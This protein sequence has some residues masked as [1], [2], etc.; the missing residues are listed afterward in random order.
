MSSLV[1]GYGSIGS[2]HAAILRQ[3]GSAVSLVTAQKIKTYPCYDSLEA[4]M[5]FFLIKLSLLI[6]HSCM[7]KH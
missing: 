7:M 4:A 5:G 2:R 6:Q 1:V 3:L